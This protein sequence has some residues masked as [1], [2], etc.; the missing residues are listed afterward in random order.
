MTGEPVFLRESELAVSGTHGEHDSGCSEGFAI[1]G[2]D[3]FD[4]SFEFELCGVVVNDACTKA[5]SLST[6]RVHQFPA[7]HTVNEPREVLHLG[8][9]HQCATSGNGASDHHGG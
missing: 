2:A 6:H 8:R 7:L 9:C 1:P 3:R 5:F 4:W